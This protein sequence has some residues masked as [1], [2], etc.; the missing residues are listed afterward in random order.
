MS[1]LLLRLEWDSKVDEL[2]K[3]YDYILQNKED[4]GATTWYDW[5]NQENGNT[6]NAM[7]AARFIGM[8]NTVSDVGFGKYD[9]TPSD[10]SK[11]GDVWGVIDTVTKRLDEM[12]D[13]L[14]REDMTKAVETGTKNANRDQEDIV[15]SIL[16]GVNALLRKNWTVN[17]NASSSL[18]MVNRASASKVGKITGSSFLL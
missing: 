2:K 12:Q 13:E 5:Y 10:P 8:N 4:H 16:S 1:N 18:G 14:T 3:I 17:V 9:A 15:R 11:I 6:G 7:N